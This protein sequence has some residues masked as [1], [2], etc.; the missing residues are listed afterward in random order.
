MR[1]RVT[2]M[3]PD[4]TLAELG[5]VEGDAAVSIFR[6]HNWAERL[7]GAVAADEW[8]ESVAT[9]DLT[10]T[11]LPAHLVVS[12]VTPAEFDVEVCLPDPQKLF[13]IFSRA[14][15][16]VFEKQGHDAVAAMI[17]TFCDDNLEYKHS[18]FRNSR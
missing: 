13:G 14:K 16:F 9:P 17:R 4:F 18:F 1:V 12:A 8:Q 7:T 6:N 3:E 10:F 5:L 11:A 2:A 15:F